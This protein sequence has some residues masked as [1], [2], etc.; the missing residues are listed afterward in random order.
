MPRGILYNATYFAGEMTPP[1]LLLAEPITP[2]TYGD[3]SPASG[4]GVRLQI[5][6]RPSLVRGTHPH[7]Q[8]GSH[9]PHGIQRFVHDILLHE[10]IHQYHMEV[11]QHAEDSYD[12]HGPRFRIRPTVLAPVWACHRS[13]PRRCRK[14]HRHLPSC[15][16]WPHNVRPRDYYCDAITPQREPPLPED[17]LYH[18]LARLTCHIDLPMLTRVC[19]RLLTSKKQEEG[20]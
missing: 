17:V 18:T 19:E 1:Y 2:R 8:Q 13:A 4:L 9:D 11:L 14:Q 3:T 15:A 6:I 16:Q 5:R 7:M 20:L 10:T 12:G